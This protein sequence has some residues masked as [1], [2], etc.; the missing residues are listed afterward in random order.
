MRRVSTFLAFAFLLLAQSGNGD[1]LW[2]LRNLGKAF[3]EN[4]LK[5]KGDTAG[6]LEQRSG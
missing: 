3:Y 5:T 1:R 2:R 4:P 6:A